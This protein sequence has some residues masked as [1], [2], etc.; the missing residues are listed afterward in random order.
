MRRVSTIAKLCE[1]VYD[2]LVETV[3]DVL[4]NHAR[5]RKVREVARNAARDGNSLQELLDRVRTVEIEQKVEENF[6]K[7]DPTDEASNVLE[8]SYGVPGSS[9]GEI[10]TSTF[11]YRGR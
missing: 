6:S 5:N 10:R 1:N 9:R 7:K 2:Q 3:A 8:V 4:Q 11:G